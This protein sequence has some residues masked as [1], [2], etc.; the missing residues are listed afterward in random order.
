M[1]DNKNAEPF[2]NEIKVQWSD[3]DPANIAFT[4]RIPYFALESIDA[5][6]DAQTG[7]NW[8]QMNVDR[9]LGTPFVHMSINFRAPITPRHRLICEVALLRIGN[10]SIRHSVRGFQD[11]V[12]CFEG[13]FVSTFVIAD[14]MTPRRPPEYL[15][16]KIKALV[17][18]AT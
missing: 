14:T 3:C 13:E 7:I 18:A 8:F 11:G 15:L 12:L 4:G 16:S 6:W 2:V 9:N 10:S 1:G 5:W 17:V